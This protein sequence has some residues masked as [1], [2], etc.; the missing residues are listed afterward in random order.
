M[1]IAC[2]NRLGLSS[3]LRDKLVERLTYLERTGE[4]FDSIERN[5]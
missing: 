2:A 1:L 5:G 3:F 4:E